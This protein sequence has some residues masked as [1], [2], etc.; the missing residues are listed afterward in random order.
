MSAILLCYVRLYALILL[1][2]RKSEVK[3]YHFI[4]R[5][6]AV[7]FDSFYLYRIFSPYFDGI[8]CNFRTFAS[9]VFWQP[10]NFWH[11]VRLGVN[12]WGVEKG[13]NISGA[14]GV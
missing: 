11:R 4:W 10:V 8:L 2:S 3:Y 5:Y 12:I 6:F 13:L 1:H 14:G 9:F 7:I